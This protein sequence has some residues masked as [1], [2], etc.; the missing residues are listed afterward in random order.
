MKI[1]VPTRDGRV[2]DHRELLTYNKLKHAPSWFKFS[3][4]TMG[5]AGIIN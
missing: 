2:D 4:T 1:A 3:R 5:H